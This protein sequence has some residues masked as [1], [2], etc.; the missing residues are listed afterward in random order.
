[1]STKSSKILKAAGLFKYG[2]PFSGHQ[3]LKG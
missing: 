2:L 3:V 1:M